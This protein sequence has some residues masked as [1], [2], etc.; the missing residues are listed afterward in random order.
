[1]KTWFTA[2]THF[3]HE[4]IMDMSGRQFAHIEEHDREVIAIINKYV[5][6]TDRLIILGDF[7]WRAA[8]SYAERIRCPYLHMI[9]GNHDRANSAKAFK[10]CE[11]VTEMKVDEHKIFC[12]HYPH[13]Y[14]PSSHYGSLHV[15]GHLHSEREETMDKA[16]PGRR[17]MDVG[18][19]NAYRLVGE[20]RPLEASE[21]IERLMKRP[22][23]DPLEFYRDRERRRLADRHNIPQSWTEPEF[24]GEVMVPLASARAWWK[25]WRRW[26]NPHQGKYCYV[27]FHAAACTPGRRR[28]T[29]PHRA[30]RFRDLLKAERNHRCKD[31]AMAYR[32]DEL[33]PELG[34]I[35]NEQYRSSQMW[36]DSV[37]KVTTNEPNNGFDPNL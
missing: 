24:P 2:D 26:F 32:T 8:Q 9:W 11:D 22:G 7:A 28:F 34:I 17:A 21:I 19:D 37:L 6:P 1:M 14:W 35:T 20:L 29:D 25:D 27:E 33:L 23:H 15:Y 36:Y 31:S 13:C 10:T 4:R 18:L 3:G 5:Q 16:F 30:D 12:S